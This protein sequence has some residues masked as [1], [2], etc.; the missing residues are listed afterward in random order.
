M[1]RTRW[2][3][4]AVAAVALAVFATTVVQSARPAGG[5]TTPFPGM[6]GTDISLPQTESAK[7]VR[8]HGS[9]AGMDVTVNQTRDLVNQAVSVTWRGAPPTVSQNTRFFHAN[10]VQIMQCWGEPDG[11]V[12]GN[13]GPPPEQC[14]WGALNPTAASELPG[15]GTPAVTSRAFTHESFPDFDPNVGTV[16]ESGEVF[17]DFRAVDGTV[18]K[19]HV[20]HTA[21]GPFASYWQNPFFNSVTTNELPGIR[22]LAD[23]TGQALITLNTGVESRG[24]GCGQRVQP[25]PGGSPTV[26]RCWIVVVPRGLPEVENEGSPNSPTE[27]V[28]TSPMR[29]ASWKNRIAI[30]LTFTPVD[31]PCDIAADQRQIAGTELVVGAVSSWQPVLC[32]KPGLRPYAYGVVSDSL[33]RQQLL[34]NVEGAPGMV[35]VNRTLPASAS[36]PK[37]PIL[38]A[39]LAASAVSVAF[40]IERIPSLATPDRGLQ[41]IRYTD[42]NLTPRLVAK[43]LTQSYRSQVEIAGTQ[44][45]KW[46]DVNPLHMLIDPD[47]LRFNPEFTLWQSGS[48]RAA[49]GLSLPLGSSDMA[50]Q[51]WEWILADPEARAWM[52]GKPDEWGMVVNPVYGTTA[53]SNSTGIPFATAPPDSFAKADPYCHQEPALFSGIV[54]PPLCSLDWTPYAAGFADAAQITNTT[55]DG[56]RIVLDRFAG[57]VTEVWKRTVSQ[58]LGRRTMFGLTDLPS[59][60][61]LGLQPARLSRAGDN[62]ANRQFIGPDAG[63][64]SRGVQSM[65]NVGGM[66]RLDPAK[67]DAGAYPLTTLTYAAV[68]PFS[69]DADARNQYAAFLD[70]A[71]GAGQVPGQKLGQLPPGYLPLPALLKVATAAVANDLRTLKP[72]TDTPT[73]EPPPNSTTPPPGANGGEFPSDASDFEYTDSGG[74]T[75]GE[76]PTEGGDAEVEVKTREQ[77][78]ESIEEVSQRTPVLGLGV[79]RF[80]IATVAVIALVAALIALEI[81][82]HPRRRSKDGSAS[83][84][85]P[86]VEAAGAKP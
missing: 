5:A 39:P 81:T 64:L 1:T 28:A 36:N 76:E 25:R 23:G 62:G 12:P 32:T 3:L 34:S 60:A 68:R 57:R 55:N 49:G 53:K 10:F 41:G 42:V 44:P 15:F 63:A 52:A 61:K 2:R 40:N 56:A 58:T 26:P 59:V 46:D 37:D 80:A 85:K 13:P 47:F 16:D 33:A 31:S 48:S 83:K 66:L 20:D 4:R 86:P 72:P 78:P 9:F 45:Y 77:P 75:D 6:A 29:P 82:K 70:H 19:D 54:P 22:T 30:E 51:V 79:G 38:Y 17:R 18:V 8:G 14:V 74:S 11:S 21:T 67:V 69:Q 35:A 73:E 71:A 43:M 65:K 27:G 50:T 7:T 84:G 24:L